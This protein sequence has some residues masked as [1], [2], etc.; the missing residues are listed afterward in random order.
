MRDPASEDEK[1]KRIKTKWLTLVLLFFILYTTL[2]YIVFKGV[3]PIHFPL[4]IGNKI[5]STAGLFFLAISYALGKIKVLKLNNKHL[6]N[7][8]IKFAG[9][10][11]FSLSAMHVFMSL[12][13]LSP[14]YYPKFYHGDMMNFKGELSMLMGV[15]SLFFFTIPAIATIPF[16]QEAVGI[17]K[18]QKGQSMGYLGLITALLH[19]VVMGVATWL[20]VDTWPGYLPPIT[21]IAVIIAI[22]PLYLKFLKK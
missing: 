10:I 22:V 11:G 18:W 8:F 5:F 17:K 9:L 6:T 1:L 2:R 16:M 3:D 15:L 13:I 4:Y 14:S 21:M 7:R 19:V 20:N 12:I